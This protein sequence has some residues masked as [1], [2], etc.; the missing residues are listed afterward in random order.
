MARVTGLGGV[1]FKSRD[2]DALL[3]SLKEAGVEA[4]ER[5]EE[6]DYGR[7]GWLMDPEGNRVELW[8]PA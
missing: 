6:Y 7:F 1:F 4:D 8:E 5:V 2:P 3:E